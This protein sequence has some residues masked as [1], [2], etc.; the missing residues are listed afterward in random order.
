MKVLAFDIATQTGVAFGRPGEKPITK[1]ID[2]G[3]G[4]SDAARFAKALRM[5]EGFIEARKPDL[6]AVEAPIGPGSSTVLVGLYACV[7]AQAVK[8]GCK[9]ERYQV[10]SIRKHFLG[11]ALTSKDYPG[12]TKAES[13]AEIKRV[14]MVR[15]RMLGWPVDTDDEADAIALWDYAIA[16]AGKA[17]SMPGGLFN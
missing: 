11:K 3:S 8:M 1:V 16:K 17:A 14:V 9:V 10:Q 12:L 7:V 13:R 4:R 15:C 2:L 6:V 5:A